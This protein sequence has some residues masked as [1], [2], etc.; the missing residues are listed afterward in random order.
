MQVLLEWNESL[1][2][3]LAET[4]SNYTVDG[5]VGNPINAALGLDGKS[6]TLTFAD[7]FPE[8]IPLILEIDNIADMAGNVAG[9]I[10]VPFSY[11]TVQPYDVVIN[12]IMADPEPAVGL[13]AEEYIE[14]YN[15]SILPID[16]GGWTLSDATD[17]S[18]AFP[19][20]SLEPGAY[21]LV[22]DVDHVALF[23]DFGNV[24][25]IDGF[26]SLNN[27]GDVLTVYS[28]VEEIIHAVQYTSDWYNNSIKADGGYSLEQID[29][30]N[31]CQGAD[32]WT[33]S[34]DPAGGTPAQPNSVMGDN[35]DELS[36][37]LTGA[38]PLSL[39]T[40]LVQF[41]EFLLVQSLSTSNF[42]VEPAVG[43]PVN[44][45]MSDQDQSLVYMTFDVLLETGVQY[46]LSVSGVSDCSGNVIAAGSQVIFGIPEPAAPGDVVI[47]E[48]LFNPYSDGYDFVEIYNNSQKLIDLSSLRLVERDAADTAL[49]DEFT[50]MSSE[51]RLLLPGAYFVI[52][53]NA[54]SQQVNYHTPEPFIYEESADM[55][56]F[57]DDEGIVQLEDLSFQIIDRLQY[58]DDWHYALLEDVNGVSLERLNYS[59]PDATE[60]NWHS[61]A[62]DAGYATPGK[63]N[64]TFSSFSG[65]SAVFSLESEVFSPDGDAYHD[66]LVMYYTLPEAGFMANMQ[67]YDLR[68]RQQA[69]LANNLLLSSEGVLTWDG[70]MDNGMPAPMGIYIIFIELFQLDGTVEQHKLK[71]T[72]A[73]K[74]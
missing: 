66:L 43:L 11:Y 69:V 35:P 65:S 73:R 16:M 6:V 29:A 49:I 41:D 57:P 27:D 52:T 44:I 48:V 5:G 1:D 7:D 70:S 3:S 17:T 60:N 51:P 21:V 18:D 37:L 14:I 13:P 45:W 8:G 22:C 50:L 56:N 36:P 9:T 55:P 53:E 32:N 26:P 68:G 38:F 25:G 59:I 24:L 42:S 4:E 39:D 10:S 23:A 58:D 64:S 34:D 15:N 2:I 72:L 74:A 71:C 28:A 62:E 61:A 40:L 33:A 67:V 20:Y 12:E 30:A 31:P 54:E 63:Q 46:T 47:N 19:A